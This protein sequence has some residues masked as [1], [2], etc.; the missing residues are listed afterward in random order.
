[1]ALAIFGVVLM[2]AADLLHRSRQIGDRARNALPEERLWSALLEVS[3]GLESALDITAPAPATAADKVVFRRVRPDV[4]VPTPTRLPVKLGPEPDPVPAA[5][6]DPYAAAWCENVT[7]SRTAQG[8]LTWGTVV[9]ADGLSSF[10]CK[11]AAGLQLL[12]EAKLA[13]GKVVRVAHQVS[14]AVTW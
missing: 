6:W 12:L 3:R 8:Q 9:L 7:V 10:E 5:T 13:N 14:P 1:M 11:P 2:I 4:D